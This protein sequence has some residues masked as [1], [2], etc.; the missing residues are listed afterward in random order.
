MFGY[1][2]V[3]RP[4]LKVRDLELYRSYYC[5]LCAELHRRYGRKGQILLSYD[6][7][8]LILLLTGAYE[9]AESERMSRCIVHPAVVHRETANR[10]TE[11]AADMNVLLS[12]LKAED[13][14]RD[15][16]SRS[17]KLLA[18]LLRGDYLKL[19]ERYPAQEKAVRE[20]V[21]K[22]QREEQ[23]MMRRKAAAEAGKAP[24]QSQETVT[25]ILMRLDRMAGYT[26]AFFGELCAPREGLWAEELRATGFYLGKFIYLMDAYDDLE[27]DRADGSCNVLLDLQAA[28]PEDFEEEVR[29]IL[30]DTAAC[31]CRAFER[32][33]IVKDVELLRNILYS[34]IWVRFNRIREE[35]RQE[36][37]GRAARLE[38]CAL[39]TPGG[40]RCGGK[41]E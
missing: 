12:Y 1:V 11:Y 40:V 21:R 34:G 38:R 18:V 41:F 29:Q 8:F 35:K 16:R 32:M 9:P 20:N 10:F 7:T 14:W 2:T 4:E 22:L 31:C 36:P 39:K 3:N 23:R 19:K 33:P 13:D 25:R 26:G 24:Q 37:H 27:K 30:L 28:R 17:A 6:C 5:G 15:D